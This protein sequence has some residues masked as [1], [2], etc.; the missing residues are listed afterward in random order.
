MRAYFFLFNR[1]IEARRKKNA[2]SVSFS[3]LY[4]Q[5][6][7]KKEVK[8]LKRWGTSESECSSLMSFGF[9][10]GKPKRAAVSDADIVVT[11]FSSCY[12]VCVCVC[13]CVCSLGSSFTVLRCSLKKDRGHRC[14][15]E[16]RPF[17]Q[18]I[19]NDPFILIFG[20]DWAFTST[21]AVKT[22][23]TNTETE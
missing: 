12:F 14:R 1:R 15:L 23:E 11:I 19:G 13:V 6:S 5:S 16:R 2:A 21:S 22:V 8:P 9:V 20:N 4:F 17:R 18:Q 10:A 3:F 7:L